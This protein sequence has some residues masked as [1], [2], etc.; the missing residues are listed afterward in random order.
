MRLDFLRERLGPPVNLTSMVKEIGPRKGGCLD[1]SS[2][3]RVYVIV[4][5]C[6]DVTHCYTS[7]MLCSVMLCYVLFCSVLFCSVMLCYVMFCYVMFC[8]V[9]L[10]YVMLCY[11]LLCYVTLCCFK[12]CFVVLC[13]LCCVSISIC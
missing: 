12:L 8:Y 3:A 4:S 9:M 10:C 13:Y 6:V 7:V 2:Q 5:S 11:V 1:D